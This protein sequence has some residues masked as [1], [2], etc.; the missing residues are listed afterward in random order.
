MII[1]W[2]K[3]RVISELQEKFFHKDEEIWT[4]LLASYPGFLG[5]ETWFAPNNTEEIILVIRWYTREQWK[6]IP[7]EILEETEQK[8]ALGMGNNTYEMIETGEYEVL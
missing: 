6:S 5:K 8:F 7:P 2:L 1:E 3:F 4:P